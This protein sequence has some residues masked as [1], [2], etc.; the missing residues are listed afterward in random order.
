MRKDIVPEEI[1]Q[2]F[3][4]RYQIIIKA[5]KKARE[6]LEQQREG[7][8]SLSENIYLYALKYAEAN[9]A[10]EEKPKDDS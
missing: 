9:L 8:I 5:A 3:K 2:K 1:G 4:N 10:S 7:R 6:L